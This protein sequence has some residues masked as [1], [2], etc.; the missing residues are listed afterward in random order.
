MTTDKKPIK[1]NAETLHALSVAS[2][3][4]ALAMAMGQSFDGK[5]D[6]YA[7]CGWLKVLSFTEYFQRWDRDGIARQVVG[8]YPTAAW[9]TPPDVW[10]NPDEKKTSPFEKALQEL[11]AR[12]QLFPNLAKLD[13]RCGVGRYG[14]L[15]LGL[16]DGA[17]FDQPVKSTKALKLNFVTPLFQDQAR[18]KTYD[19]DEKSERFGLPVL[20]DVQFDEETFMQ[21]CSGTVLRTQTTTSPAANLVTKTVHFSRMVHVAPGEPPGSI[22]GY[23]RLHAP[24]NLLFGLEQMLGS[25]S[26]AFWRVAYPGM[27]IEAPSDVEFDSTDTE[28]EDEI[29]NYVHG[30]TRFMRLR[31]AAA[32]SLSPNAQDPRGVFEV[33]MDALAVMTKSPKRILLGNE[34]GELASS[35]DMTTW[36]NR[37]KAYRK[38]FS[39]PC[40]VTPVLKTLITLQVLPTPMKNELGSADPTVEWPEKEQHTEVE[41]ADIAT[42]RVTAINQYVSGGA[43]Q[44]IPPLSF[45]TDELGIEQDVAKKYLDEISK[46]QE[47]Y[48]AEQAG[49]GF[50]MDG[51]DAMPEDDEEML[52]EAGEA[53]G[54]EVTAEDVDAFASDAGEATDE[55]EEDDEEELKRNMQAL[56]FDESKVKRDAGKFSTTGGQQGEQGNTPVPLNKGDRSAAAGDMTNTLKQVRTDA[57]HASGKATDA[58]T[59]A[60]AYVLV[61]R[62]IKSIDRAETEGRV[63]KM[64]AKSI[65]SQLETRQKSLVS[66]FGKDAKGEEGAAAEGDGEDV[67]ANA[68]FDETKHPRDEHG[69]W[70]A[71]Q[72]AVAEEQNIGKQSA[73]AFRKYMSVKRE[74]SKATASL[75][76]PNPFDTKLAEYAKQVDALNEAL[77]KAREKTGKAFAMLPKSH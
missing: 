27:S 48:A 66:K 59:A 37:V 65:R 46:L 22:Y 18:I 56:A 44:L 74:H 12:V 58:K 40:V 63:D 53:F 29:E 3:R 15:F 26:E 57:L 2:T 24:F 62:A 11:A 13:E 21:S 23:S 49:A 51:L 47:E 17:P 71:Y 14:C 67:R 69:H 55:E 52:A 39:V 72:G 61:G 9:S 31:G 64:M 28:L 8:A 77:V 54:E 35:Q 36:N 41:Q 38:N 50:D 32:K 1:I 20:Y 10:D 25:A 16:S 60:A 5:R 6:I 76:G 68:N 73:T 7:S 45:L 42:K 33:H 43:S 4:S 75:L 19:T 34:A 30:L 70:V